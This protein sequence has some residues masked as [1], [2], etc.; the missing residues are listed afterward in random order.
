MTRARLLALA[1]ATVACEPAFECVEP[2]EVA[3][4]ELS[5]QGAG[6]MMQGF[7]SEYTLGVEV[8][9][10]VVRETSIAQ[11]QLPCVCGVKQSVEISDNPDLLDLG[12][13][14]HLRAI[15]GG[16]VI[17]RNPRLT[18]L[19]GLP[20]G[21]RLGVTADDH[22]ILIEDNDA[23]IDLAGLPRAGTELPGDLE[24][25]ANKRLTSLAALPPDL[26]RVR[27]LRIVGNPA[28]ASLA[29]LPHLADIGAGG[30]VVAANHALRDLDGLPPNLTHVGGSV[31]IR[32]NHALERL[33]GVPA[34]LGAIGGDLEIAGNPALRDLSGLPDALHVAG[35]LAIRDDDGLVDLTGLPA[36]L[37]LGVDPETGDSLRIGDNGGLVDLAGLP[38]GI[39]ALAGSVRIHGNPALV[40]LSGLFAHLQRIDGALDILDNLGLVDLSGLPAGLQLGADPEGT[41]LVVTDNAGLENLT[42][43]PADLDALSGGLVVLRNRRLRDLSG[44]EPLREVGGD[45]LIGR[46]RP[47]D[48]APACDDPNDPGGNGSLE[49]LTGL[50]A[51]EVVGGT[52]AIACNP[53]LVALDAFSALHT[54]DG[55]LLLRE[56]P[57]LADITGLGG[58][59]GALTRVGGVFELRCSP[60]LDLETAIAVLAGVTDPVPLTLD[61]ACP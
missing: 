45:L 58:P 23:L 19:A 57:E 29:G 27:G 56:N 10:L 52:L 8:E 38:A 59:A 17:A 51:L 35:A 53:A 6:A 26:T 40:D 49:R 5:G 12:G 50:S 60:L 34:T 16:I 1:W 37:Q 47:Q 54:I 48:L 44:L 32:D 30:L 28:L 2:V 31:V 25:V 36:Q 3:A 41:S 24:I 7:C 20:Q 9:A 14:E 33:V 46:R 61:L 22:S 55:S 13:L 39:P 42:G 21:A 11:L 43:F 15:G 18:T 4:L